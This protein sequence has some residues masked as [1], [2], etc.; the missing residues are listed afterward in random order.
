MT[1]LLPDPSYADAVA[2]LAAC[3]HWTR[4]DVK[5]SPSDAAWQAA[6]FIQKCRRV[7]EAG[8]R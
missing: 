1:D 8:E 3:S 5:A 4:K 2:T 6:A 7:V